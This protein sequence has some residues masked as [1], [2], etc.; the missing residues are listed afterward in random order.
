MPLENMKKE[1]QTQGRAYGF[2]ECYAPKA[3]LE[4]SLREVIPAVRN[5]E[6]PQRLEVTLTEGVDPKKFRADPELHQIAKEAKDCGRIPYTVEARS[7]MNNY[8]TG[9]ELGTAIAQS[10]MLH[11][12]WYGKGHQTW[13]RIVYEQD[14]EYLDIE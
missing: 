4:A 2:I 12:D 13:S 11:Q 5:S 8:E 1:A 10:A 7:E 6:G 14:G 9:L 3:E